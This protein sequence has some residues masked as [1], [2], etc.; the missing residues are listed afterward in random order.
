[1]KEATQNGA[2][3]HKLPCRTCGERSGTTATVTAKR[4]VKIPLNDSFTTV[5]C[6]FLKKKKKKNENENKKKMLQSRPF[7]RRAGPAW[8]R[9]QLKAH[10]LRGGGGRQ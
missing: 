4:V 9:W 6:S 3:L 7:G 10:A 8:S 2:A 5:I 1:M